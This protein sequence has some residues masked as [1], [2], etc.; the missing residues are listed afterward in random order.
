MLKPGE[1]KILNFLVSLD[2]PI[3]V[4]ATGILHTLRGREPVPLELIGDFSLNAANS[5][6][7]A[8]YLKLGVSG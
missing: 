3:L 8:E 5:L 1:A 4:R 6:S 2:C 7:A